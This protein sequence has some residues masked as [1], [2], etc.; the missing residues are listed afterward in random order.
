MST[1]LRSIA[2]AAGLA[3]VAVGLVGCDDAPST[4]QRVDDSV[5]LTGADLSGLVGEAPGG[6]VAFA[7]RKPDGAAIW[8]QIPV[9]VDERKVVAFGTAPS[10]NSTPGVTGTVYGTS[11]GG[12]SALQYADAGTWVGADSN[13]AFDADDELVFMS[14]DAGSIVSDDVPSEPAGVVSGSG[15][16]V[17]VEDPLEPGSVGYVYLFVRSG[18]GLDPAAG[19]DYVDYDF[20]L[21]SGPY[22]TTYKRADGPNPET[23]TVTTDRYSIGFTDRWFETSWRVE[24]G[25]DLLDGQKNVFAI[26]QCGR[27]NATFNDDEG[28]FVANID[29]PVRGIRSYVGANSGPKTQ[30]THFFYRTHERTVTDLRVHAIPA[31]VDYIDYSSA[32]VG[33]TYRSSTVPGGVPIDGVNDSVP[34]AVPEWEAMNGAS[35]TVVSNAVFSF[36][37]SPAPSLAWFYGDDS[38]PSA[39]QCWGDSAFYGAAGPFVSSAIPNTDPATSPYWTLQGVR[40]TSFLPPVTDGALVTDVAATF[41]DQLANPLA[42]S[43]LAYNP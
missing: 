25:P 35:G 16:E 27:S 24:G 14:G 31:V 33:S 28:A 6:I 34:S 9:Q 20:Q 12:P 23:S 26:G 1:I 36:G 30:R 2:T 18:T 8:D 42:V 37:F 38:T 7:H 3:A 41:S 4:V 15:V 19:E 5:V 11:T 13:P 39:D 40:T 17:K 29:G 21:T 22:K 32:T 10:T 43:T